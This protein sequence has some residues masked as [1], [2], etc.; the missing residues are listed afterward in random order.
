[1][2]VAMQ[3]GTIFFETKPGPYVQV[4]DKDFAPWS[5]EEGTPQAAVYLAALQK[6]FS[7]SVSYEGA[8]A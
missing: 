8:H 2:V 1:M 7:N 3:T 6:R 5:P 4:T